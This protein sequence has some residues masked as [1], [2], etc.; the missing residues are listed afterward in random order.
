MSDRIVFEGGLVRRERI[1][2]LSEVPIE[3]MRDLLVRKIAT[4]FPILPT[5]PV[6]YMHFDGETGRG[7]WLV[8]T[9]PARRYIRVWHGREERY[10]DGQ[11]RDD[12]GVGIWHVQL[13]W[14]YFRFSFSTHER[15][16]AIAN[17]TIDDT[18]LFWA[19]NAL[20]G[21][22]HPLFP[23]PVPNVDNAGKIC[24]G[25]TR[26]DSTSLNAR[27]DDYIN[28]FTTTTFNEDLGHRTPFGHSLTDWEE[29]YDANNPLAWHNWDVW[30]GTP[31]TPLELSKEL[32]PTAL[33]P[34]AQ[35]N[36]SYIELPTPPANF[37]LARAQEYLAGLTPAA[38]L[39]LAA[40]FANVPTEEVPA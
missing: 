10:D 38:R 34:M 5:N 21:P 31:I 8:E 12:E 26:A 32:E 13:P 22:D 39:R 25:G 23:A 28:N 6:R 37:T 14:Q 11:R 40:A 9:P 2:T 7:M 4:T 20:R 15:D 33:P 16:G 27:I 19:K 35:L 18:Y 17:F 24:W 1:E 3:S 30:Q 29:N 36:P